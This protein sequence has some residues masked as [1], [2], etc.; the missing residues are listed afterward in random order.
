MF[1]RS[2][3]IQRRVEDLQLGVESYQK[4]LNITN[5]NSYRSDLKRREAYSAY[6]NPKGFI[7]QNKDKK[8]KLMRVDELYKFSDGTLNDVRIA[9]DDRLKG[10]RMEYLPQTI[11]RQSDRER[12]KAM[13]QAI[14][15][16]LKSR[17]IMRSLE[18]FVGG[19][20]YEGDGSQDDVGVSTVWDGCS[21]SKLNGKELYTTFSTLAGK[22]WWRGRS[23]VFDLS[24]SDLCPSFVE[25]LTAKEK[26]PFKLEGE[27]FEPEGRVYI[28]RLNPFG[29]AKLTTFVVMCKAYGCEP[30]INLF[31]GFFNLCRAGK[32]LTFAKRTEKHILNLLPKVITRIGGW[33]ERFFYVQDSIIPAN[34]PQ[35]LSEQNKLDSKSFKDKLP[36]NI[37]E[38]PLSQRL[39]MDF[40]NFIYTEDDEN[41]AFLPNKPSSSFGTDSGESPK[42][43]L[44]VVHP[45]SVAD[46]IKDRKC[47]TRGGSSRPL[48]KRKLSPG[49]LTSRTT[50]AKTSS[51]KDD[52]PFLTVS[53]DDEGLPDVLKLKDATACHLKISAITPPAWK[54]HLDNHIDVE[55]LDLHDRSYARQAVVDNAVNKRSRREEECEGL[56]VKCDAAMTE[57]EKNPVVLK[58][59]SLE[60]EKARLEAVEVSLCKEVEELKQ[61]R[62]EVVSKVIPCAA[63]E[64]VYSDDMGSLVGR[65][66]SSTILYGRCRAYKQVADMKEPFYLSKVKGY[67]SSYKK[68]HTQANNDFTTATFPWLDDI[69]PDHSAP[70][71]VLLSKK[72]PSLQRH[73]PSRT[74]VPF[75]ASQK[76]TTSS[77]LVSNLMSPPADASVTK[78]HASSL[79]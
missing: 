73:V 38:N 33:H 78:P 47:K 45:R 21:N 32:W 68:E 62:R 30:S 34:Y 61:D 53:N 17:R 26:I 8:N 28:S 52:A 59:T 46:R 44:F 6:S 79:Q 7:Y 35:L 50:R 5:L 48:V 51:S 19:R 76:A 56:R 57:F 11:W 63:M 58:V 22:L 71:E 4:K 1:T 64:L 16:Q 36:P 14:D 70:I 77:A 49:S 25:G 29:C 27:A 20:P 24:K 2:I 39:E 42:P 10:I 74:Q 37:E 40:R 18:R 66:V 55:L 69:V 67:R 12:A 75:P 54:N 13:I 31:R 41:L 43:E 65:L 3:V 15:K 23:W 72:P 9:L 60:A